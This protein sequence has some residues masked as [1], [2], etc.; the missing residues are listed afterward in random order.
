MKRI[1]LGLLLMGSILLAKEPVSW[2]VLKGDIRSYYPNISI[3]NTYLI[4]NASTTGITS[5]KPQSLMDTQN[6]FMNSFLK[7][8]KDSCKNNYGYALDHFETKYITFGEYANTFI[9]VSAN[10]VCFDK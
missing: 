4:S 8:A 7:S 6:S 5:N 1:L 3:S 10:I 9:F 2:G